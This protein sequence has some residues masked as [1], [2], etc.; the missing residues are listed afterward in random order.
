MLILFCDCKPS[1]KLENCTEVLIKAYIAELSNH[2]NFL[3]FSLSPLSLCLFLSLFPLSFSRS[4][5]SL[6]PS[7]SMNV[8]TRVFLVEFLLEKSWLDTDYS[9]QIRIVC[10]LIVDCAKGTLTVKQNG[11]GVCVC[12]GGSYCESGGIEI[13]KCY[14]HSKDQLIL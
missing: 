4:D 1:Y 14:L 2:L 10:K 13:T 7:L 6:S 3:S 12:G 11:W 9:K 8:S 5:L